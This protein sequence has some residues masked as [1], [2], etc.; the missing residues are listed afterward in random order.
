VPGLAEAGPEGEFGVVGATVDRPDAQTTVINQNANRAVLNWQRF[1][2]DGH[3]YVEFVQPSASAIALN[4]VTSGEPSAILGKL[5]A[6]G[7]VYLVNTAGVYFGH[8]AVVDVGGLVASVL[9]IDDASILDESNTRFEFKRAPDAPTGVGVVNEGFISADGG[10]VVLAEDTEF[11]PVQPEG[12]PACVSHGQQEA[13][14]GFPPANAVW[15]KKVFLVAGI[16]DCYA[17]PQ[18]VRGRHLQQEAVSDSSR[19]YD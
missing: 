8:S 16:I 11:L 10:F 17:Q 9:D 13:G 3:E 5:T 2:I 4:R 14:S 6:N 15:R 12:R 18:R 7:Q 1:S 19:R